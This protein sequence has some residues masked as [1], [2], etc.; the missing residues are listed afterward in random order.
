MTGLSSLFQG[1]VRSRFYTTVSH[2]N[3]FISAHLG[4]GKEPKSW[5]PA[6][7]D[8]TLPSLSDFSV[9]DFSMDYIRNVPHR[10]P[11]YPLLLAAAT[12]IGNGN[13]FFLGE[14]SVVA[15]T[16][17][18][19]S[20]YFGILRFFRSHSVAA[21][22][23]F[24]VGTNAFMWR[25]ASARLLTEP[26]YTLILIWVIIAFLQYLRER[27]L[28]WIML[29]SLFA[30]L[31]YLTRP[32]GVFDAAAFLGVLFA[33]E[34]VMLTNWR[35]KKDSNSRSDNISAYHIGT[36]GSLTPSGSPFATGRVPVS[37]A[38]NST[39]TSAYVTNI[40]D[41][42]VSVYA[43]GTSGILTS[44]PG[45]PFASGGAHFSGGR[46]RGQ[47]CLRRELQ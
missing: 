18:I 12:K 13:L 45:S 9:E 25:T 14:I 23:A 34:L 27:K 17:A 42:S 33:A 3:H 46:T 35:A 1:P 8:S 20:L 5:S 26:L 32:N 39:G 28:Y 6:I 31:D 41:G 16:L 10:Q 36:D 30:G 40:M 2:V 15:M 22:A 47:V 44:V 4:T 29:G 11:L 38:L 24:C 19:G 7:R 21:I 43:V 37:L